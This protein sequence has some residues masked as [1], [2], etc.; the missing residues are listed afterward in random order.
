MERTTTDGK[1]ARGSGA[2]GAAFDPVAFTEADEEK[3]RGVRRM[4]AIATGALL[5]A[6]LVFALATWAERAGA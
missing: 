4:K 1:N 6:A 3:R 2:A 5:L